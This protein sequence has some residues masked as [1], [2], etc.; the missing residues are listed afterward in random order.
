MSP[1]HSKT[2]DSRSPRKPQSEQ[3]AKQPTRPNPPLLQGGVNAILQLQSTIGNRGVMQLMKNR[4]QQ[5][6]SSNPPSGLQPIQMMPKFKTEE[7]AIIYFEDMDEDHLF[8]KLAGEVDQLLKLAIAKGWEDL[9]E[10]I[11]YAQS[12]SETVAIERFRSW[13]LSDGSRFQ[14]ALKLLELAQDKGWEQLEDLVIEYVRNVED[15]RDEPYLQSDGFTPIQRAFFQQWSP[16]SPMPVD[17]LKRLIIHAG[18]SKAEMDWLEVLLAVPIPTL[19]LKQYDVLTLYQADLIGNV[20]ALRRVLAILTGSPSPEEAQGHIETVKEYNYDIEFALEAVAESTE[21]ADQVRQQGL[22]RIQDKLTKDKQD[23]MKTHFDTAYKKKLDRKERRE[24]ENT[25]NQE[26]K[27]QYDKTIQEEQLRLSENE[28]YI[29]EEEA[30]KEKREVIYMIGPAAYEKWRTEYVAFFKTVNY[31]PATI[32]ALSLCG[33]NFKLTKQIVEKVQLAPNLL[34][35]IEHDDI[36]LT[37]YNRCLKMIQP[38]VID[39]IITRIGCP[40]FMDFTETEPYLSLLGLLHQDN[41]PIPTLKLLLKSDSLE[42]YCLPKFAADFSRLLVHFTPKEIDKLVDVT[43]NGSN[44]QLNLLRSLQPCAATASDLFEGLEVAAR[45]N[46]GQATLLL[47]LGTLPLGQN[48]LQI[49]THIY[50]QQLTIFNRD[51]EFRSWTRTLCVLMEDED[52]DVEVGNSVLLPGGTTYERVCN[53]YD[54]TGAFL[55]EFVVHY[56]P[57]AK[58]SV[59]HPYGSGAHIKPYSGNTTTPRIGRDELKDVLKKKIP[60]KWN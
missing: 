39:A 22:T 43:P 55:D 26:K 37:I 53:I 11:E 44:T 33:Q 19:T 4:S 52:Y 12:Q 17:E 7:E 16:K 57:G 18:D 58:A 54:G 9:Q 47:Q 56:H 28:H 30:E 40:L 31:H 21:H 13:D 8:T 60:S 46:W 38:T 49:K 32:P 15:T 59:Q 10:R 36:T 42:Q 3:Q 35:L 6:R 2:G 14:E 20:P 45:M 1:L 48:A 23:V 51:T 34:Q 41:V 24:F 27:K 50:N 5:T 29:L 25:S